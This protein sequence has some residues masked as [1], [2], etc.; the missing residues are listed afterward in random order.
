MQSVCDAVGLTAWA[1]VMLGAYVETSQTR[2]GI[3]LHSS[4][5]RQI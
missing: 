5:A 3:C 4:T 2:P 1:F